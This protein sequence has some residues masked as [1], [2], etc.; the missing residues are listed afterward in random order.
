MMVAKPLMPAGGEGVG[1]HEELIAQPHDDSQP[2]DRQ[3]APCLTRRVMHAEN[4]LPFE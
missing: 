2:H 4:F 1:E 3:I